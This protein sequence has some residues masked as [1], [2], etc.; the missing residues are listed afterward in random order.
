M[1]H[2]LDGEDIFTGGD[3]DDIFEVEGWS[4]NGPVVVTELGMNDKVR[5]YN[6]RK[7]YCE[8]AVANDI[9]PLLEP[10]N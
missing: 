9:A 7:Q 6:Y 10:E 8:F 1:F 4:K 2:S 3:G 5:F